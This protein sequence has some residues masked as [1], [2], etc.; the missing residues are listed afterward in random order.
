MS[1]DI[2]DIVDRHDER[3]RDGRATA[4]AA[5]YIGGV[6][7]SRLCSCACPTHAGIAAEWKKRKTLSETLSA[8][9]PARGLART[10]GDKVLVSGGGLA[11][12]SEGAADQNQLGRSSH[13]QLRGGDV[14]HHDPA[15]KAA[16]SV[17]FTEAADA[18]PGIRRG[19]LRGKYFPAT[20]F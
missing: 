5:Y 6:R 11:L 17:F 20:E 16:A 18:I 3:R 14:A 9:G 7:I 19:L 8:L 13:S 12:L 15:F 1:V 2:V 4:G 10:A